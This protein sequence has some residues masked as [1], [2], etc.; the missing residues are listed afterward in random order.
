VDLVEA[1][2]ESDELRVEVGRV[3]ER[4]EADL[5]LA[6]DDEYGSSV[7]PD[8]RWIAYQSDESSRP[9]VYVRDLAGSGARWQVSTGGGEE[10]RWSRDGK[11]LFYREDTRLLAVPV[12]TRGRFEAGAPK[13]VVEGIFNLRS[14]TG[15]SYDVAPS[16]RRFLMV[17]PAVDRD[18]P[19]AV[20][21][22]LNWRDEL[23]TLAAPR[24]DPR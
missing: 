5:P 19:V 1:S 18:R 24:A 15:V 2:P 21:V 3:E 11:E 7:S 10:P 12:E 14:D 17:R 23:E 6:V 4:V 13:V 20:R 8:G 16:G 22:V 9:E